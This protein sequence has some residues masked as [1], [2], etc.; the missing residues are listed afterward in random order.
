MGGVQLLERSGLRRLCP[1][2]SGKRE[3]LLTIGGDTARVDKNWVDT[4]KTI[5][6]MEK[7]RI[8]ATII[9]IHVNVMMSTH[10]Y[11]FCGKYYLQLNRGPIGLRA[12][13]YLASLP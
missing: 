2:W 7:K 8:V 3:D 11:V 6:G 1:T 4:K 9:E 10:V 12:K 13:A 5:F